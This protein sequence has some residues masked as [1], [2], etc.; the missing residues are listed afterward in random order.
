M[1]KLALVHETNQETLISD[2]FIFFLLKEKRDFAK[3]YNKKIYLVWSRVV[4]AHCVL[5]FLDESARKENRE[6][7]RDERR[8]EM[9][10]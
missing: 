9:K 3:Y 8:R 1:K 6:D 2:F 10:I 7:S 4:A 5:H